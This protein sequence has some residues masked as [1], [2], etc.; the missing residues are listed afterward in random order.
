MRLQPKQAEFL[1][2]VGDC[3]LGE[4]RHMAEDVVKDVRLLKIVELAR[5][6]G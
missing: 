6:C 1:H 2:E 3:G 4:Q 5:P